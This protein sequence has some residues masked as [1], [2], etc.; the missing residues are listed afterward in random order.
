MNKI[1][2]ALNKYIGLPVEVKASIWYTISSILQRGIAFLTLPIFTR[3][4]TTDQYGQYTIYNSWLGIVMIFTT[5]NLQY[6]SFNTA[7][8]KFD[9]DRDT[10]ISSIQGLCLVLSFFVFL[11]YLINPS[12][13][14]NILE[15]PMLL[16]VVMLLEILGHAFVA[17]WSSKERFSFHYRSMIFVT[18]TITILSSVLG[19]IAVLSLD[20][21]GSARIVSNALIYIIFGVLFFFLNLKR[22][23][24]IFS[25]KYWKYALTFNIPLIPYYLS[26]VIFNQS[27]RI[28][29][30]QMSGR[31]KAG[32][33]GFAFQFSI[34]LSFVMTAINNSYVPWMY[35]RIKEKNYAPLKKVSNMLI[36]FVATLLILLIFFGPEA[37]ALLGGANYVEAIWIVPPVAGSMLFL[38]LSQMSINVMFYYEKKSYM[39]KS[40]ITAAIVNVVFNYIG[41]KIFGYLAA[42]YVTLFSYILYAI[43][44]IYYM[45]KV[46]AQN[47][48]NYQTGSIYDL[49]SII[50]ISTL[51]L[52]GNVVILFLYTD[53]M[54]RYGFMVIMFILLY[55]F[56]SKIVEVIRVIRNMK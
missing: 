37:I 29:I 10:Y 4:L 55:I 36:M 28:M 11:I 51:F 26:E 50:I 44:N 17:F 3:L 38:F 18:L 16:F 52:I 25:K 19:V 8:S 12:F 23:K 40:S 13:W 53:N 49:K 54:L 33:Y 6:G 5:L 30:S 41:I 43:M 2:S 32:I 1:K 56:R 45:E 31:D 7:M 39:V 24:K 22:G 27:D 21:K 46:C 14:S 35:N 48:E 47:I 9:K 20:D 42:G 34:L 15:I